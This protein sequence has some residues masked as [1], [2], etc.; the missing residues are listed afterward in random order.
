MFAGP[1]R[2]N[3]DQ[4]FNMKITFLS[5][6]TQK[7]SAKKKKKKKNIVSGKCLLPQHYFSIPLNSKVLGNTTFHFLDNRYNTIT[8]T[9][10]NDALNPGS[11]KLAD[12]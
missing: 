9:L 7:F 12:T 5:S 11:L 1:I 8:G 2:T 6:S 4:D 3:L 10:L